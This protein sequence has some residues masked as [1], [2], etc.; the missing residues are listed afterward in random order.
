MMQGRAFFGSAN[1][2]DKTDVYMFMRRVN[3]A[4]YD[5]ELGQFTYN[6]CEQ[7]KRCE[8]LASQVRGDYSKQKFIP[9]D[10]TQT[11]NQKPA[12]L[13][14]LSYYRTICDWEDHLNNFSEGVG[15]LAKCDTVV[16][17]TVGVTSR[18][19]GVV[20]MLNFDTNEQQSLIDSETIDQYK[21]LQSKMVGLLGSWF[22]TAVHH[23]LDFTGTQ[24][25]FRD[26]VTLG[27]NFR[28]G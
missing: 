4:S 13:N 8:Y 15:F 21:K 6:A 18:R 17:N 23:V 27:R 9:F 24:P 19:P 10:S 28:I 1:R 14:D 22:V 2:M 26:N 20:V 7:V 11:V 25:T 16:V 3:Q 5:F 12:E